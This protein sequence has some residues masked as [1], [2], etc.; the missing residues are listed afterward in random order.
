MPIFSPIDANLS[1]TRSETFAP[2]TMVLFSSSR[3]FA[4][5]MI[6]ASA[7]VCAKATN[8][9]FLLTKSVSQLTQTTIPVLLL[10]VVFAMTTPSFASRSLRFAAT[11]CPCLRSQSM[12]ASKS[13]LVSVNALRQSIIPAP[14]AW[15]SLFISAALIVTVDIVKF[16]FYWNSFFIFFLHPVPCHFSDL[17]HHFECDVLV[18]LHHD[19]DHH[20]DRRRLQHEL[21][22]PNA[23]RSFPY[24]HPPCRLFLPPWLPVVPPTLRQWPP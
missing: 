17:R 1:F 11:F 13:P 20:R 15:R 4:L 7:I 14:V 21:Q 24:H 12:A 18:H 2:F 3:L 9:A 5:L 10:A 16:I 6:A 19:H 22:L 8:A 23:L